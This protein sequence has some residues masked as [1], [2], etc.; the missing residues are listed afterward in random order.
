M[1]LVCFSNGCRLHCFKINY[2]HACC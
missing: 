1:T 2:Y